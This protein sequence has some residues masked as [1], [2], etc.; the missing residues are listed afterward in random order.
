M[1]VGIDSIEELEDAR[2]QVMDSLQRHGIFLD[3][4]DRF[5][6]EEQLSGEEF[7]I[8]GIYDEIFA[9]VL[10]FGKGGTLIEIEK[11]ICYIDSEADAKEIL[12]SFK[13]TK[14]AKIFP[15]FRGKKYRKRCD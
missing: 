2:N 9:E 6:V 7:Y 13:T 3:I 4:H 1:R 12:R 11:D 8:G 14:I 5:I 15:T 10:L